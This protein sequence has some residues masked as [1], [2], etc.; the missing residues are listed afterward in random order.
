MFVFFVVV[1]LEVEVVVLILV[2]KEVVIRVFENI[3]F[4]IDK[5]IIWFIL[6]YFLNELVILLLEYF[7]W[8]FRIVGYI[9]N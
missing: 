4:E 3:E 5:V 6:F 9:D 1:E 7:N 2:E 8:K